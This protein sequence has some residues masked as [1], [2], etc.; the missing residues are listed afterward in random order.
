VHPCTGTEARTGCMAQRWS[1]GIALHFLDHGTR[2]GWGVS[3]TPQLLFTPA[4]DPV[5]IVQQAGWA[6][7]PVWTA[8]ENLAPPGFDPQTV[9]PVASHYTDYTTS[10]T[11][12]QNLILICH[13]QLLSNI[14]FTKQLGYTIHHSVTEN[15]L[16]QNTCRFFSKTECYFIWWIN[17]RWMNRHSAS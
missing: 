9:Q 14:V 3:I 4:K 8:V 11:Y 12:F 13:A 7:G 16:Q 6:P 17:S 2:R 1:R 10:L 5:P 15:I